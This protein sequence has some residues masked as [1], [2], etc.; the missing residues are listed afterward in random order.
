MLPPPPLDV[1]IPVGLSPQ[2]LTVPK[3]RQYHTWVLILSVLIWA[4]LAITVV[5]LFYAALLG[6][7]VWLGNGLLTAHLRAEAVR[8]GSEQLPELDACF[9]DVCQRLG[10]TKVP[11]LYVL[12]S[13][14]ALN[15]FV[16][17]FAGRD[18]VVVYSSFW[19]RWDRRR[20]RCDSSSA[21]RSAISRA[22]TSESSF[23]SRRECSFP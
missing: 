2:S 5:G 10:V 21:M 22:G 16:T 9:N 19:R 1:S 3:E 23:S 8:V 13:G 4:G 18:F 12:Q 7:F 15:A 20:R 6:F 14:G 17:R 11:A